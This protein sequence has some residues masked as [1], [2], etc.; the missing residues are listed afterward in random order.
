MRLLV[1]ALG[2]FVSFSV[3][4]QG[5]TTSEMRGKVTS[6]DGE[7]LIGAN[8]VA[9]HLP[10][11]TTFGTATDLNGTYHIS[12][13]RVGGPYLITTTYTGYDD[14]VIENVYLRLGE[15]FRRDFVLAEANIQLEAVM[16]VGTAGV[17]GQNAGSGTQITA[18]KM[19]V[20][21]S[22]NRDFQDFLRLSP[23]ANSYGDGISF[24]GINNRYN[25]IYI[26]GAVN[27]D[28]Y[29]LASSGTNGGQTGISPF[30]IDII[31]QF[32]IVLSPYDVTLG[33][34]AGGGIN[35]VTRSGT[36]KMY[37]TAY[38]FMQNES[39]AGKTNGTL[40]ER[41]GVERTK[42]GDFSK[43]TYGAS[44][45]GAIK[46]DKIFYFV[47]AEIQDDATPV[48]FDV[49]NYT[50]I[51]GRAS[52]AQLESLRQHLIDTYSYDPGTFGDT[53]DALE[54]LKLFGKLDF[55]L[56]TK[57]RLTLRHQYT[58]A[59]QY[60]RNAGSTNTINFSNNGVY[61][62]STTNSSA[63]ELHSR[64]KSDL[65]N[66]LIIGYTTVKDDRGSIGSDFPYMFIN[67]VAGGTIRLGTEEF[68]TAN[69]LEQQTF[70]LTDN[71]K[72]YKGN[73]T[74]TFGTHNE[75]Y[76]FRN[77]FIGQNF[78]TYRFASIDDFVNGQNAIE[79]DRSYSLLDETT[80]DQTAA[81]ADFNAMQ[82]GLYAQDEWE[83]SPRFTLTYG[84]R[85]DVPIITTDPTE[86]VNFNTVALPKMQAQYDV[87][88]DVVA[89]QAPDGQ[90]MLSPRVGFLYDLSE[91]RTTVLR[92][93]AGIFTSRVPFVWPG[94][95]FTNNGLTIGRVD[96]RNLP[97]GGVPFVA[98]I[99]NQ[100]TNPNFT[101]PSGQ[102]D[103][104]T[105]NFKYP[106]VFRANLAVDKKIAGGWE[107][108][109]EGLFTKTLNNIV[110]TNINNDKTDVRQWTGSPDDRLLF[111][112]RDIDQ[113][114]GAGVYAASNTN[115]GYAYN[116]TASVAKQFGDAFTAYLAYNYN[117][118]K[119]LSEGTSSQNSSQWR[120]QISID[121]RNEPVYGRSD[122]AQGH[123]F[124]ASLNY[125]LKWTEGVRTQVALFYNGESG[126]P[127]S[128]VVGG[129]SARN[130]NNETGS[131][132]RNRSLMYVPNDASEINLVDYTAG[133]VT[134]TA[135]EQWTRLNDYIENDPGLSKQRGGYAEKNG[136]F[137]PFNHQ[138][139]LVIRQD[140]GANL[141]GDLHRLQLSFDILNLGNL[142]NKDW[143]AYYITPGGDFNNFQ[144]V[145]FE[146]YEADGTTPK[147][148]YR[149]PQFEDR[150]DAFEIE[151]LNSRWRMRLGIRYILN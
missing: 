127:F 28:V 22:L 98:D 56:G 146:G 104:F 24:G 129:N 117:D 38:Y 136:S 149:L 21:P 121:G 36:N 101:V 59:E 45:G 70:T 75:F 68:S 133:G 126:E 51:A 91:D 50:S 125:N 103:L 131:T 63:L 94:A 107:V 142:L 27:N 141:G 69:L 52:V 2:L 100:Y 32:Q 3:F 29:G 42:L 114:Y 105:T 64:F 116:L 90:I 128:Y 73:H 13:M 97:T 147:F 109:L 14:V 17:A 65:S 92:G 102:V 71:L 137:A 25:A 151:G 5:T 7:T 88:N 119:A 16:V 145:Q 39:L 49:E 89:G 26:D 15:T 85:V 8:V 53:E 79:Y 66:N 82:L 67:D 135:A 83:V 134:V 18:E 4:G 115:K 43:K 111:R 1:L 20:V 143:G 77:V 58:K 35:A 60:D 138:F 30:S 140:L 48:P 99:Q 78:G 57:H 124:I 47:N 132:S 44:L 95:M 150:K 81:A 37:A 84:L 33:G 9:V 61:F 123:R 10:S 120:G 41:L 55:N 19:E 80:G 46:K 113:T 23:V 76:H 34:F 108:T 54:G 74:F 96:E 72:L 6:P 112:R 31:D 118:A 86:D 106:Q 87:A 130:L 62:P 144:L 122:F 93:G 110:Y 12:G 40:A 139:N 148:T 11:G